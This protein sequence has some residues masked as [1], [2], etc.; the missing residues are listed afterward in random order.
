MIAWIEQLA[1]IDPSPLFAL[2]LLPYLVFLF[3]AAK[4]KS[5]HPLTLLGFRLTLLFVAVTIVAAIVTLRV[6]D[7]EL[8]GVDPLHGGAEAFLT[9]S[10][11]LIVAGL[12]QRAG[13][14]RSTTSGE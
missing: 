12:M 11:G 13:G 7:T 1:H 6:F 14:Q 9:L 3:W 2:S 5:L 8:V 4:A 10:N